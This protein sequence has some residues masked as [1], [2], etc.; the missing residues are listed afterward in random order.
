MPA[1]SR[2]PRTLAAAFA[3][4]ALGLL[5]WAP[6]PSPAAAAEV[7]TPIVSGLPWPSGVSMAGDNT[8]A[9]FASWR[10]RPNDVL[11]N[12]IPHRT[13]EEIR[14]QVSGPYFKRA[15][16]QAA[17]CV[18]SM[19]IMPISHAG[20]F[21]QCAAGAFD[22]NHTGYAAGIKAAKPGSVVRIGWEANSY[23]G[24]PWWITSTS[25]IP[26]YVACWRRLAG[27]YRAA[28]L[29][30]DW[31]NTKDTAHPYL[32]SYPGDDVVDLWSLHHYDNYQKDIVPA[33][34][35]A[36]AALRGKKV[37]FPEWGL[38]R[39]GDNVAFM[40]Q[41]FALFRDNAPNIA[42]ETY[43]NRSSAHMLYPT[44]V[45]PQ[46]AQAYLDLWRP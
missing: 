28:G 20:Q 21:A 36:E 13:W 46:S 10:G 31:S 1:P 4:L 26:A 35:I 25:Q 44:T 7:A 37:G 24:H 17:L 18:V 40:Q 3:A 33:A 45:Y 12:F 14:S 9:G 27:I 19:S 41:T 2:R 6:A 5:S 15:C 39:K 29:L 30:T 16:N 38:R 32:D 8:A 34:Y 43:F 22:V 23:A 11:T 42:Y